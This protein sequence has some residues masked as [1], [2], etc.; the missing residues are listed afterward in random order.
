MGYHTPVSRVAAPERTVSTELVDVLSRREL[1][2]RGVEFELL[3]RSE[4]DEAVHASLEIPEPKQ[5]HKDILR[6]RA[7]ST[8]QY[9]AALASL[10]LSPNVSDA[11]LQRLL[12]KIMAWVGAMRPRVKRSLTDVWMQETREQAEADVCQAN[13]LHAIERG[14]RVALARAIDETVD[15]IAAQQELLFALQRAHREVQQAAPPR[16]VTTV[17]PLVAW[18]GR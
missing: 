8:V 15:H 14:D 3:L 5:L 7:F 1:R 4:L 18:G 2:A 12:L 17:R 6:G 13:A 9:G 16:R 10:A 11:R